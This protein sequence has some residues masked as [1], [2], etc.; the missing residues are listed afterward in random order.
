MNKNVIGIDLGGTKIEVCLLDEKKNMLA[1]QRILSSTSEGPGKVAEDTLSLINR[2]ADGRSFEAVGMGTGGTYDIENDI[3]HGLPHTPVYETPGFINLFRKKLSVPLIIENDA[4]CLAL[5]EFFETCEGKYSYVMAVIIGTGMGSGLILD[6]KLYKG[7]NGGAGEVGHN[8]IDY[9]GRL[10]ECGRK[11]CAEAY[12]S[13]PSHSRRFYELTG[14]RIEVPELYKLYEEGDNQT[15]DLFKDSCR[16]MS[17]IFANAINTL[18]LQAIIL[19]GGVSNLPIWYKELGPLIKESL[20]G[21]PREEIPIIKAK[22][23]DSAGVYGA[24]YLALREIGVM[25]F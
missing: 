17:G 18:D 10:C 22:L 20:F 1:R 5:A 16:M 2:V 15:V 6:N 21:P 19:G 3:L 12:L 14:K 7:P 25:N 4:N 24:A 23:G 13:G 9:N 11:G 8:T